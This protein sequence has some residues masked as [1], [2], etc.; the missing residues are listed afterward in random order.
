MQEWFALALQSSVR[1]RALRMAALIGSLLALIN[2]GDAILSG[3]LSSAAALRIA[4]TYLVP[5]C[6][7][8]YASVQTIRHM[9]NKQQEQQTA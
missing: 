5:Y 8:T 7:S 4:L 1:N 6:V 2:H 9:T 3:Q